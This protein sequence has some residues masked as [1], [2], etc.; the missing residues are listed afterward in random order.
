MQD[1]SKEKSERVEIILGRLS[2]ESLAESS[3]ASSGHLHGVGAQEKPVESMNEHAGAAAL[4]EKAEGVGASLLLFRNPLL[5]F[6]S[7]AC[8][9][10]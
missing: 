5:P 1:S 8:L 9:H 3:L 6:E 10:S 2:A 4:T 7:P